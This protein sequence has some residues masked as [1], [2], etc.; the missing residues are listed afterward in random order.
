MIPGLLKHGAFLLRLFLVCHE[1]ACLEYS[2]S[3]LFGYPIILGF[4]YIVGIIFV[5]ASLKRA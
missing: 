1:Y 3:A 4:Y 2:G 5:R